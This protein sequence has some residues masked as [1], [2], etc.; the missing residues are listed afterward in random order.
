MSAFGAVDWPVRTARLELRPGTPDDAA[1]VFAYS[2][3]PEVVDYAGPLIRDPDNFRA[4]WIER[5]LP[6]RIVVLRDDAIIGDIML[7]IEDAW[8][9]PEVADEAAGTQAELG[10][11]FDPRHHGHGYATEAV[12]AVLDLAFG[13]LGLRRVVASCFAANEPSWRLME[14]L[15]MRREGTH[16]RDS[17]HRDRGWLDGYAYALLADEWHAR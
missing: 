10:Y 11:V 14:R 9:Q 3:W 6:H 2:R 4:R 1:A 16:L 17:M 12:R 8:A 5:M 15:G 7:R 13:P